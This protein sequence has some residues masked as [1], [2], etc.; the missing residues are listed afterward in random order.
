MSDNDP[1]DL[2]G[3]NDFSALDMVIL[4]EIEGEMKNTKNSGCC[5]PILIFMSFFSMIHLIL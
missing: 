3:D 2:D 5:V 1:A 4:E